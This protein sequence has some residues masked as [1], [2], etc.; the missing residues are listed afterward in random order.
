MTSSQTG[1]SASGL[2]HPAPNG[3]RGTIR[4]PGD[5]SISHRALL[6]GSVNSG[7]VEVGGFLRSEDT[8][9]TLRAVRAL[10]VDVEES[11]DG[12]VVHGAGWDGL[13]EPNDV[14]DVGNSGTLIRLLPGIVAGCDFL[15]VLSGDAS[16]RR[17]PMDRVLA[18]LN[19][20]GARVDGRAA[21]SLPPISIRGGYIHG[22]RHDLSIASAQVK[23]CLLLAGLRA[24]GPTTVTE[25]GPSRDHTERMIALGGGRIESEGA[26]EGPGSVKVWPL[27]DLRLPR[28]EVPG[29]FSS[30]AFFLVAAAIVPGSE[31]T[32]EGVGLNPTRTG[33]LGA[34][35]RMGADVTVTG[36]DAE[37][38]EPVGSVTVRHSDLVATDVD[39]AEV[40]RLIDE[41]PALMLAAARASG[42]SAIRGA[43]ELRVKESDRLTAMARLLSGLGVDVTQHDDGLEIEG[44][45]RGWSGDTV[46]CQGDHRL[47]MVGAVAGCAST[48]GVKVDDTAC[49]GVSYPGFIDQLRQLGGRFDGATIRVD[50]AEEG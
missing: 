31:I 47:A 30:A 39:P 16:I 49:I 12:L 1:T 32:I 35:E 24:D 13:T 38:S 17:R 48:E 37:T 40:P 10:G 44:D 28:L 3:L 50:R 42:R 25:P 33:L 27:E 41:L 9:A 34:L 18:P 36:S 45:P 19:S 11:P 7:P 22:I 23:S 20:A 6:L 43:G 4:V 46:H 14:I 29:D 5:K 26:A 15:T 21:G 2:F 8:Y